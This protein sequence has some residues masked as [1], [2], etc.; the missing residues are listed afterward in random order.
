MGRDFL[1][2]AAMAPNG[3][4]GGAAASVNL[5]GFLCAVIYLLAPAAASFTREINVMGE[6]F[7]WGSREGLM[8]EASSP[9]RFH[10]RDTRERNALK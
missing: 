2:W 4:A 10:Q 8:C 7:L 9:R 3:R 6:A 5:R 1:K